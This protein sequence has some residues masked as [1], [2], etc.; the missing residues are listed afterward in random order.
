MSRRA[1][2]GNTGTGAAGSPQYT[3]A[4]SATAASLSGAASAAAQQLTF[5]INPIFFENCGLLLESPN[6]L[7]TA[8]VLKLKQEAASTTSI[9]LSN[10]KDMAVSQLGLKVSTTYSIFDV[11][12]ALSG[13]CMQATPSYTYFTAGGQKTSVEFRQESNRAL[14][15]KMGGVVDESL[16]PLASSTRQV[17][18]PGILAFLLSQVFLDRPPRSPLGEMDP[19]RITDLVKQHLHD[20]ITVSCATREGRLTVPDVYELRYLLREFNSG[21]EQPFGTGLDFLWPRNEKTI[22]VAVLAQYIRSHMVNPSAIPRPVSSDRSAAPLSNNIV[23][24]DL[25]GAMFIPPSPVMPKE[26]LARLMSSNYTV[27]ECSQSSFYIASALP[28][29][30]LSRLT[31]CTLALG[32]IAGVLC[33]DQCEE[34]SISAICGAVV[35]SNCRNVNIFVCTNTP[36]VLCHRDNSSGQPALQNVR[37]APYNSQYSILEEHLTQ[38]GIN[39]LLN[40]WNAG[41]PSQSFVLPPEDFTPICFPVA[42]SASAFITTRTNP[43]PLPQPYLDVLSRRLQRFQE[44]ST[45]LQE[46]YQKLEMAGRKDLAEDL[47]GTIQ[48]MFLE[49]LQ[50]SGQSAALL[51]L[52][53]HRQ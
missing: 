53:H 18:L 36:P 34:C 48:G 28:H 5:T 40:L 26:T 8:S 3:R 33:I 31:N 12:F 47:K 16:W 39:P 32:P 2:T 1:S 52:L 51:D 22:E 20:Y 9:T 41:L 6:N 13:G 27:C 14:L 23:V 42:P 17:S 44:M 19:A 10:W 38:T 46:A 45:D 7:T 50:Q 43:C 35:V 30:R 4:A 11:F 24:Q 49:W 25:Q 29:T 21:V 37:F 15:S